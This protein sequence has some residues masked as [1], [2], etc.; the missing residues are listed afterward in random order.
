MDFTKDIKF[1]CNL[2]ANQDVTITYRGFLSHSEN[3]MIVY[4]FGENWEN[5]T[6]TN[7]SKMG[8]SFVAKI[9]ILDFDTFNFCFR[10]ENY[11]WDN[12]S[13]CNYISPILPAVCEEKIVVPKFDIDHLIDEILQPLI[14][15]EPIE[16]LQENTPLQI[17]SEPIDL[18]EEIGNILAQIEDTSSSETLKEYSTL[19]EILSCEII[20]QEPIEALED[21]RNTLS[22]EDYAFALYV[23]DY[24]KNIF[25]KID[26]EFAEETEKVETTISEKSENLETSLVPTQEHYFTVSPRKLG[27]FYTFRK[28]IKLAFYKALVKIPQLI[29]GKQEDKNPLS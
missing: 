24:F 1:D 20:S 26:A 29:F 27:K 5:T 17:S 23:N 6:E 19:E 10:N 9:K 13:N 14:L 21:G 18:G 8:D 11:E 3:A 28:R 4:G 25:E 16:A 7:M 15:P 2:T 22:R 12:N